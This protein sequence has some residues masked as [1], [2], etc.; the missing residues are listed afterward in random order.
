MYRRE[1]RPR[2]ATARL[3]PVL[4]CG[5][6]A[7]G[8]M[9]EPLLVAFAEHFERPRLAVVV[10]QVERHHFGAPQTGAVQHRQ[11]RQRVRRW[12]VADRPRMPERVSPA[13]QPR[14]PDRATGGCTSGNDQRLFESV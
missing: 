4:E 9:G 6:H 5:A 2:L 11:E 7:G 12:W 1:Q 13:R 10:G 14:A 8:D 3:D